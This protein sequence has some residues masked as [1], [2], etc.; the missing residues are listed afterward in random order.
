[1]R[2]NYGFDNIKC[3]LIVCVVFGHLLEQYD[4]GY[5][6]YRMIYLFHMPVFMFITG[7]FAKFGWKSLFN[8]VWMYGIFQ[9]A[10]I[11]LERVVL[12]WRYPFD[13]Y[14]PYW[15][16]WYMFVVIFY[17]ALIPLYR[18]KSGKKRIVVIA[19][20]V[21]LSIAAGFEESIGYPY[22][23]SRFFVFQ[24]YFILG[25][26]AKEQ[27]IPSFGKI[28]FSVLSVAALLSLLVAY[29]TSVSYGL[30]YGSI[31]Y[32]NNWDA[33]LRLMLFG[34]ACIWIGWFWALKDRI[35]M[36]IPVVSFVGKNTLSVYLIHG[37]LVKL[38]AWKVLC[39]PQNIWIILLLTVLICVALG[40]PVIGTVVTRL[41]PMAWLKKKS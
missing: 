15:V 1:M 12:Q 17:T 24:P 8:K 16:M 30:L 28:S 31:G 3:I 22:S 38:I 18:A 35:N 32:S 25:F 33:L 27:K 5:T 40:N 11:L 21:I 41:S 9:V 29:M 13:F 26:Y 6:V 39:L 7:Y 14:T 36:K 23:L 20:A 34:V 19:C 37:L 4:G 2:R 10:F